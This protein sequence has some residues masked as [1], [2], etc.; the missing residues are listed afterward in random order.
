VRWIG[1]GLAR[2]KSME[3]FIKDEVEYYQHQTEGIR[4]LARKKSFILGDDMGLGKSL[5][6]LTI[7]AIDIVQGRG[8]TAL[9]VCPLSLKDN[10]LDEVEKYT[11]GIT[12]MKLHGT[13]KKRQ[14]QL[15]TFRDL[16]GPK[17]LVVNY[18]QVVSHLDFLNSLRFHVAI[19]DEA[20][21][22]KNPKAKLTKACL[23]LYSTRSMMLTGTP[24][25]NRVNEVWA[26][27]YRIDPKR[28]KSYWNF[29]HRFCVYGGFG[30]HE[31]IGTKNEAELKHVLA[32][33]MVRRLK[34]DVLD[35]P[36][37][38]VIERKVR[39][40]PEQRKLYD[41][42]ENEM[43]LELEGGDISELENALTKMLRLKQICGTTLPF[44]GEDH[45]AKLD[46]V[47][48]EHTEIINDGYHVVVFTQFRDVQRA[49][50][51]RFE[52]EGVKCYSI[53]GDTPA[54]LRSSVVKEWEA[55][56]PSAIICMLQ[57]A[58]VGLNMVKAQH[59][60]LVDKLYVPGLNQQAIDRLHRIG[61]STTES[62]QVRDYYC[63][64]TVESRVN[65]ILKIKKKLGEDIIESA[66]ETEDFRKKLIEAAMARGE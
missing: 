37:V 39:L 27:L 47:V 52:A 65:Q 7:F 62:I 45:S 19:F 63:V 32:D 34:K 21:T 66:A 6:A 20:H 29:T 9:V 38:Q 50:V 60:A 44:T 43:M 57:V 54:H 15:E 49:L 58:G 36:E 2:R 14:E 4:T 35:L 26:L 48:E 16:L 5:Q 11:G 24:L 23:N 10:W 42:A 53:T 40:L 12:A 1:D 18:Q 33:I 8:H 55:D 64:G 41:Q 56:Q 22:M 61:A 51:A 3:P 46:M 28:Y 30:G 59:C 17:I 13:P 31:I 25:L